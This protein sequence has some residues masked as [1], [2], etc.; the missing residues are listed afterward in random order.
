MIKYEAIL[1]KSDCPVFDA[2]SFDC[3]FCHSGSR[4]HKSLQL[5]FELLPRLAHPEDGGVVDVTIDVQAVDDMD[6]VGSTKVE[7]YESSDGG[8]SWHRDGT[9]LSALVDG[10]LVEDDYMYFDTPISHQGTPGYKYFAVVTVYAEDHTGSDSKTYET[11]V[12][13][14]RR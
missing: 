13:M 9:Y 7:M 11:A 5:L 12:V 8:T 10:M 14:A 1:E 3:C 4:C 6:Y 2:G